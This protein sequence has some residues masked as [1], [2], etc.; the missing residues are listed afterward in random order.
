MNWRYKPYN[1]SVSDTYIEL[2]EAFA[3][4]SQESNAEDYKNEPEP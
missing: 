4:Q 2:D 3:M 1:T